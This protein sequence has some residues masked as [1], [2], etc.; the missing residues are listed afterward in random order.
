V[1]EWEAKGGLKLVIKEVQAPGSKLVA[2]IYNVSN[3]TSMSAVKSVLQEI[4]RKTKEEEALD[5]NDMWMNEDN[6]DAANMGFT[7]KLQV[8]KTFKIDTKEVD[9]LPWAIKQF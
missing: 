7:L 9:S 1:N 3:L 2:V 8:P 5:A 6:V 4:L